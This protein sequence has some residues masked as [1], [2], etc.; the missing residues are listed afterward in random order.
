MCIKNFVV[1]QVKYALCSVVK[2]RNIWQLVHLLQLPCTH[3]NVIVIL[4]GLSHLFCKP[5]FIAL[6][7]QVT[8]CMDQSMF[9]R[10]S[11]S[12]NDFIIVKS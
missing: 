9:D 1:E 8:M 10:P 12:M 2:S 11:N 7:D 4:I 3:R 5:S 6:V